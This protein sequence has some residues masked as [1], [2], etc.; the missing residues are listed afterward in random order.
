MEAN[1]IVD[2]LHT[3]VAI[4]PGGRDLEERPIIFIDAEIWTTVPQ[5]H[6]DK[7]LKYVSSIFSADTR[8][9]GLCV[10]IN[11]QKT[12]WRNT[13]IVL[14]H[15]TEIFRTELTNIIV[16][17]PEVFWD[18][19]KVE[20]CARLKNNNGPIYIPV[21]R[22]HKYVSPSHLPE[23]LGGSWVYNHRLWINNRIRVEGFV[24][25][26]E[27]TVVNLESLRDRLNNAKEYIE[28][29]I[30]DN[31]CSINAETYSMT[32]NSTFKTVNVEQLEKQ[33]T[34]QQQH[35]ITVPQDILDTKDRI[36]RLLQIIQGK[37]TLVDDS[38]TDVQKRC[39][40][41][42]EVISIEDG[43]SQVTNWILGPGEMLLNAQQNVGY[44]VLSAEDLKR[45]HETLELQCREPYSHYA[46]ILHKLDI[47]TRNGMKFPQDLKSQKD[48]MDF[49]CRS[50][51]S[52]VERRR[53]VLITSARFFRLVSEYFQITSSVY[54]NLMMSV[55]LEVVESA[56]SNLEELHKHINSI[57][58]LEKELV[59]EGEKLSDLLSIP[60]KDALGRELSVNYQN[61]IVNVQEIL[62][63]T[64]ARKQLFK[65]SVELQKLTLQ[66]VI[67]VQ[68]YEKNALQAKEWLDELYNV[69]LKS[70]SHVGSSVHEIQLQKEEHQCFQETAK[71]TFEFG[72]QLLQ[73]ALTLRQSCKLSDQVNIQ[74]TQDIWISWKKLYE[75]S[76]E[77][78]T[79]LRVSAVFHRNV[80]EYI[81]QLKEL[82]ENFII[83]VVEE[84]NSNK[85]MQLR[86]TLQQREN[87]LLEVGRMVRLGRL[88]KSRLREPL[89]HNDSLNDVEKNETAITAICEKLSE[90]TILAEQLDTTLCGFKFAMESDSIKKLLETSDTSCQISKSSSENGNKSD[91]NKSDDDFVT[92]SECTGT[93]PSRASSFHT[94]SEGESASPWWDMDT[95][96][97]PEN[98][99]GSSKYKVIPEPKKAT[100]EMCEKI[101]REVTETRKIT[102]SPLEGCTEYSET[103]YNEEGN[104]FAQKTPETPTS[105]SQSASDR[106]FPTR[107][108]CGGSSE[109]QL[110]EL[111]N[112]EERIQ[113]LK[114]RVQRAVNK[115]TKSNENDQQVTA[116]VDNKNI[117]A[118]SLR[119]HERFVK[120]AITGIF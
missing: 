49:V 39:Q 113:Q 74:L 83:S 65:D 23:E 46:E 93:P 67:H 118:S 108:Y 75:V 16:L 17:R 90:V 54:E 11:A 48:F 42:K 40:N 15:V 2:A 43:V 105:Q 95:S 18:K 6:S 31:F 4:I 107:I 14:H 33:H 97:S 106:L 56:E 77:Q 51:A 115:K 102:M 91:S 30:I 64:I 73:A 29:K 109:E 92:A 66:Q 80:D 45:N 3:K 72:C 47:L 89:C 13:R 9:V 24:K 35:L 59:R 84:D 116:N 78:L 1:A 19:Q 111:H 96:S 104:Q 71:G 61:D 20:N 58:M 79:R 86:N 27:N 63:M 117:S 21:S 38:W 28:H 68:N 82:T 98:E 53:N 44:D 50:F 76:Q 103:T 41:M 120:Q 26:A 22:L 36:N 55:D 12:S 8:R 57:D 87:I 32:K 10:I 25:L 34:E 101:I 69:L 94:A 99:V 88:L 52:R 81:R 112:Y 114:E 62:E 37:M 110:Q 85:Q 70:H 100:A 60:V 119:Y 5:E 7:V